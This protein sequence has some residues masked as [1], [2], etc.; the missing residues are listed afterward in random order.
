[1]KAS[2]G[3]GQKFNKLRLLLPVALS[4]VVIVAVAFE[5]KLFCAEKVRTIQRSSI[6]GTF[7]PSSCVHLQATR[8][9][10]LRPT[11]LASEMH[12]WS[13]EECRQFEIGL[14]LYGKDFHAIHHNKV[15]RMMMLSA[16]E[17]YFV[18]NLV[19]FF[20]GMLYSGSALY[21]WVFCFCHLDERFV[22]DVGF[23]LSDKV[24]HNLGLEAATTG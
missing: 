2:N 18:L 23:E 10:R 22:V 16:Q 11:T 3:V 12:V 21:C 24:N 7:S 17:C 4:D 8:R 6:G 14:A 20:S 13:Q 1:M 9:F 15:R 19:N 5:S